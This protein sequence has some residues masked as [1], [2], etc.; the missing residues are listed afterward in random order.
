MAKTS[1][2]TKKFQSKH[3]KRTLD[4][5]KK[6]QAHN[7]KVLLRKKKLLSGDDSEPVPTAAKEV[8]E[9]M[10]VDQFFDGGFEVPKEKKGSKKAELELE[11]EDDSDEEIDDDVEDEEGDE[12][13]SD[14]ESSEEED[15]EMMKEDMEKLK[16]KDPEFY[17]YLQEND[18]ELL[19]FEGGNPL[20]MVSDD[21]D[22]EEDDEDDEQEGKQAKESKLKAKRDL[23]KELVATWKSR[24]AEKPSPKLI[25][26]ICVG[27]DAAVN[28][29]NDQVVTKFTVRD[30]DAFTLLIYLTLKDVPQAI[31]KLVK[32]KKGPHGVRVIPENNQYVHTLTQVLKNHALSVLTLLND[33]TNTDIAALALLSLNEIFPFYLGH[34]RLVKKLVNEVV[35]LWLTLQDTETQIAAFAFLNNVSREFPTSVLEVVLRQTYSA[36]VQ[37][38]HKVTQRSLPLLNFCKNLAA[39]LYGIDTTI[40]Y[41][42]GFEFI[43]Q[44][45]IHLRNLINQTLNAKEGYKIV[46]NWQYVSSLDF[47]S[48]VVS[49]HGNEETSLRQLVYPLVQVTLGT[50]RLI[51]TAQFYPLRFY[52]VRALLRVSQAT[53]TYIPIFPLLAEVLTSS[54]FSKPPKSLKLA[55]VDFDANIKVNQAYLGTRAYFDGV[56]DQ[57]IELS[58]E[59]FGLYAKLVAFPELVTPAV[60]LLRRFLKKS[61]NGKFNRQ[62]GQLVEKLNANAQ[63]VTQQR[64]G[65]EYGPSNKVEVANFMS[66]TEWEL[67]PLGQYISVLRKAKEER[68]RILR[69]AM[70]DEDRDER[71]EKAKKAQEEMEDVDMEDSDEE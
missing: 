11:S 31:Q 69:Q 29:N 49:L 19:D 46:Y 53:G 70:E 65:V 67:T 15:E 66:S 48:R 13:A 43:R 20:D 38:S 37:A 5:R 30:P 10:S 24:L 26:E 28:V 68:E 57:F 42:V 7:K 23:T 36:L 14:D 9:D 3:L 63:L 45:A 21:D 12:E 18:K 47:W 41:Q 33:I 35:G 8:F 1:K 39:E 50:I 44:A 62:L 64:L 58:A 61:K 17:K 60:L 2:A 40:A 55:A 34:K 4:H 71:R 25:R 16:E 32:Y 51:P 59:F 52:L 27:F 56:A 22:D 6:V 54:M